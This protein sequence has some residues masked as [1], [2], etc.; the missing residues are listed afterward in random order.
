MKDQ[1][2]KMLRWS[3][4]KRDDIDSFD[5]LIDV[6]SQEHPDIPELEQIKDADENLNSYYLIFQMTV[7]WLSY[8]KIC[9]TKI[10]TKGEGKNYDESCCDILRVMWNDFLSVFK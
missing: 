1:F 3:M 6:W 10:S 5:S 8:G 9:P 4:G 7:I 2:F